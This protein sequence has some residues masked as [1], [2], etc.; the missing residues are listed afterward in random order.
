MEVKL[1]ARR[2]VSGSSAPN[3]AMVAIQASSSAWR[4][5]R[6]RIS[7]PPRGS[8]V[9]AS[10]RDGSEAFMRHPLLGA[11]R[12]RQFGGDPAV[13]KNQHAPA[14]QGEL[15]VVAAQHQHRRA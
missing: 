11:I 12:A 6:R 1:A 5:N 2:N 13:T 4:S 7:F 9:A 10:G 8:A 15:L 3:S 14:Q